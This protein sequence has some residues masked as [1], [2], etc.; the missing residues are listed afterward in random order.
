MHIFK[1]TNF[2]FLRWRW[3]AIALSSVDHRR[4]RRRDR[5]RRG[6]RW[7]SSSPAARW[8]SRSSSRPVSI[9]QVRAALDAD[10][11]RRRTWSSRRTATRRSGRCM[12][13]VP[14]VGAESGAA[15]EQRRPSRSTAALQ[16]G[17]PRR[18]S[19]IVGT[20]DRRAGGRPRADAARA[21][22]RRC[23][24]SSASS[25]TSRSA[26]SSAS[27]SARSSPPSTICSSRSRSSRSSVRPDAER[28]RRAADDH[29]LLDQRHDRHLRSR[30][31]EPARRCGA[32]RSTTSSTSR[33]TRRWAGPIIT[34]GTAL[35]SSLALFL[36]GGDVLR[37]FAFTMV[38]G[39]ITG[40]YST[41]VH[42]RRDRQLLARPGADAGR[43]RT[44]RRGRAAAAPQ[45]PTRK[46]KPQR[47]ARAS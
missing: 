17:E 37:G 27:R 32:I 36:F 35:L 14:Q 38:V 1:N 20:R 29:R 30:A 46:S 34:S 21:S 13:R 16:A 11:R 8:S 33:S 12:I 45:Q 3:H 4:R 18:R 22:G 2:D 28:H 23:C 5:R 25:P 43:R 44:R 39:I 19:T 42:R 40:T 47:K 7:A 6:S 10:L 41:R 9:E 15:L 24:R 31:R 26:F